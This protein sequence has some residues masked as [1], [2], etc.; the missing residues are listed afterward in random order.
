MSLSIS[1]T[2]LI[3]LSLLAAVC[4]PAQALVVTVG[5][6]G[7]T[8]T[9]L[10]AAFN[11][12]DS[13]PGS[14]TIRVMK[15][16]YAM[17]NGA[18]YSPTVA[19]TAVFIEGGYD[20]C[21]SPSPSGDPSTDID[22]AVF[23]G[24]G[25]ANAPVIDLDIQGR[26]G[27]V[28]FRRVVITGGDATNASFENLNAGGGLAVRGPASVL[29]GLGTS[30]RGNT[31]GHG[32]GVALV[33]GPVITGSTID[34][35]DFYIDEGAQIQGNTAF[36]RGGGIFCGGSNSAGGASVLRHGA[37]VFIDGI[38]ANNTAQTGG[39][40]YCFGSIEGGGGFQ[41]RP[42]AN[43]TAW[44]FANQG[45]NSAGCAGGFG[46]LDTGI[47]AGGDGVR[48][49]GA[50]NNE[51]GLLAITHNLGP[52]PGLCLAG[53]FLLGTNTLPTDQ[54]PFRLQNLYVSNQSGRGALGLSLQSYVNLDVRPS[55]NTVTCSF[56]NP[57]PCVSFVDNA[58]DGSTNTSPAG[59]PV[60]FNNSGV[61][62]LRRARIAG[63]LSR[64]ELLGVN[65]ASGLLTVESSLIVDNTVVVNPSLP[66]EGNSLLD[67]TF[68]GKARLMHSTV[69]FDT[70]L[71]GFFH[72]SNAGSI[73][74]RA[75]ILASTV[76]SIQPTLGGGTPGSALTRE[77]CGFFQNTADFASHNV[78]NDPTLGSFV[79]LPPSALSLDANT[80]APLSPELIDAC[81]T[82][83][84]RDY[85]GRLF[86]LTYES[87]SPAPADIGAVEAQLNSVYFADGF[88]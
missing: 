66:A 72:A 61:L 78:I 27:T 8:Y 55:G 81:T 42:R 29:I 84:T 86:G 24:A 43:A 33:G 47:A 48:A 13:Q 68:S 85:Y 45:I 56:F 38:I 60:V 46:T 51:N 63:N 34:R 83:I 20:T 67:A 80:Y 15:G 16:T 53:S 31:A 74:T 76:S 54:P 3:A 71:D 41:P 70:A 49:I 79:T 36:D 64:T 10:N 26:V 58:H 65:T 9:S 87:L 2:R 52:Q 39:A 69:V 88:E 59:D 7:C 5:P 57:V 77:Y 18:L 21:A 23:D 62:T 6:S 22:R 44:I 82:S 14:H 32:G 25:G 28:Q 37:I 12:L 35:I 73:V 11:A 50:G 19:Q 40:F 17:P 30:I 4:A 1:R 75:S